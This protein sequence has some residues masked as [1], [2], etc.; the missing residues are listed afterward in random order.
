MTVTAMLTHEPADNLRL[1]LPENARP[2][3]APEEG[4]REL[5]RPAVIGNNN[6]QPG[7]LTIR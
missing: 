2:Q 4:M 6:I 3:G 7:L 5:I 1:A